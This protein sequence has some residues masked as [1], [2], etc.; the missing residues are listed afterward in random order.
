M[1]WT[2]FTTDIA[3]GI[4]GSLEERHPLEM[5]TMLANVTASRDPALSTHLLAALKMTSNRMR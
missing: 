5:E 4:L 1:E 3:M 2:A